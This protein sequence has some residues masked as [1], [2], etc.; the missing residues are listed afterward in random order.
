MGAKH[1]TRIYE[2]RLE[3]KRMFEAYYDEKITELG[4]IEQQIGEVEVNISGRDDNNGSDERLLGMMQKL[5]EE[6]DRLKK[7]MQHAMDNLEG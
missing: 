6:I 7:E 3:V 4:K 5:R 1:E 2:E